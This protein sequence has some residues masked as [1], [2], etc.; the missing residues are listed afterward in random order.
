LSASNSM[1]YHVQTFFPVGS[2]DIC[3][4]ENSII[5]EGFCWFL[6]YWEP[7]CHS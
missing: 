7:Y 3:K 5:R 1:G 6:S 2:V 4:P